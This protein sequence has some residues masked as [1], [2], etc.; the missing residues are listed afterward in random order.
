MT[1]TGM[2]HSAGAQGVFFEAMHRG[3]QYYMRRAV[4]GKMYLRKQLSGLMSEDAVLLLRQRNKYDI[5]L[6]EFAK[7]LVQDRIDKLQQGKQQQEQWHVSREVCRARSWYGSNATL[8]ALRSCRHLSPESSYSGGEPFGIYRM[9]GHK[10][11][12]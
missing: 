8:Y 3:A 12:L 5:M 4:A 9:P 6:W 11:P 10:G 7:R 1:P 2:R